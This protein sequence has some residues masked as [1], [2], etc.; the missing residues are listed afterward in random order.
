MRAQTASAADCVQNAW[1]LWV[2]QPMSAERVSG[3][4]KTSRLKLDWMDCSVQ[5]FLC[6][7]LS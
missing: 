4:Y 6:A 7:T 2:T 5:A 1:R 3:G